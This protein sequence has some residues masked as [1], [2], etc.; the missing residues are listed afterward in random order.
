LLDRA[1]Y[2]HAACRPG[3][4]GRFGFA[5]VDYRDDLDF[6]R[7]VYKGITLPKEDPDLSIVQVKGQGVEMVAE[8]LSDDNVRRR[9]RFGKAGFGTLR[10]PRSPTLRRVDATWSSATFCTTSLR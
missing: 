10:T 7:V 9:T 8:A 6:R 2:R 4:R 5:Y 3:S 1:P